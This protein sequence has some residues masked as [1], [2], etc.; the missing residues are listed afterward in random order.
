MSRLCLTLNL[1]MLPVTHLAGEQ[2]L[3]N[4]YRGV[5]EHWGTI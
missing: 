3:L 2:K 4:T 1:L 5:I